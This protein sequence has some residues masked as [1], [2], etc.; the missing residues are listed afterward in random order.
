[1]HGQSNG[2]VPYVDYSRD[3]VPPVVQSDSLSGSMSRS[4]DTAS[5]AQYNSGQSGSLQRIPGLSC[6]GGPD[7]NI[8]LKT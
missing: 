2:Y 8:F 7:G 6:Y 4:I 3:Y 5:T 1:M